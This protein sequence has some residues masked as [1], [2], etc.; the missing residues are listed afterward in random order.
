MLFIIYFAMV[1]ADQQAHSDPVRLHALQQ[2]QVSGSGQA[3]LRIITKE[4]MAKNAT[5]GV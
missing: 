4:N 1:I 2:G 5:G 3:Q